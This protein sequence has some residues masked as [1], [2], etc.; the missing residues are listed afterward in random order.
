MV[1]EK[2]ATLR[3]FQESELEKSA[4]FVKSEFLSK[5]TE[6][7]CCVAEFGKTTG[8]H[9]FLFLFCI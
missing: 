5:K 6:Y 7:G 9:W 2:S 4:T 8:F 3:D 1:A